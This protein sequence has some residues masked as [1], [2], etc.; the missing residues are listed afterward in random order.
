VAFLVWLKAELSQFSQLLDSI[1]GF[2]AYGTTLT[3]AR[4]FQVTGC[5]H[6]KRLGCISHNFPSVDE[7][8]GATKDCYCKNMVAWFLTKF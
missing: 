5:Y 4:S 7:V 6:L 3:V 8:R 1:S 2:V